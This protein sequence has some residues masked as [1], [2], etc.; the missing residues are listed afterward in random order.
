M[1][2][3]GFSGHQSAPAYVWPWVRQ[4]IVSRIEVVTGLIGISSLAAGADQMFASLVHDAYGG[5]EVVIPCREYEETFQEQDARRRY[6]KLLSVADSVD[7]LDFACPSEEA[8]L[9]VG[10]LIVERSD[11]LLAV[12]DGRTARG[13]GGTA[14]VVRYAH[15]MRRPVEIIWPQNVMR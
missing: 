6:H 11:V 5:L 12:W 15:E 9:T 10:R 3:L 7:I 2:R 13:R 1:T 14:D 8:Y 4:R